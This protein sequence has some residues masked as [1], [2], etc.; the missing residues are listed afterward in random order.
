VP[1][2][3]NVVRAV[4]SEGYGRTRYH[5]HIHYLL[6]NDAAFRSFFE[7][8]TDVVPQFYI[9]R[10]RKDLG[11]IWASLPEG[12]LQHDQNAF[13]KSQSGSVPPISGQ[14]D[15]SAKAARVA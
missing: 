7:Q 12:A 2:W 3:L 14:A 4:S 8:E 6:Q 11:P 9:D 1:R 13:L 5:R 15:V 10:I